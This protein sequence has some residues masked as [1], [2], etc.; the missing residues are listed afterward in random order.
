M[1]IVSFSLVERK[2]MREGIFIF[3]VHHYILKGKISALCLSLSVT[4]YMN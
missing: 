3:F 4:K 2:L 1:F